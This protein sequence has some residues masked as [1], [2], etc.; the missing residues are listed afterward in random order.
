MSVKGI[1]LINSKL[2]GEEPVFGQVTVPEHLTVTRIIN[3]RSGNCKNIL[4]QKTSF[5]IG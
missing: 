1:P 3:G 2:G 4:R 5:A